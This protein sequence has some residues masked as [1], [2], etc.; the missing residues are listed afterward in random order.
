MRFLLLTTLFL[1]SIHH[2]NSV[3]GK[4]S[5]ALIPSGWLMPPLAVPPA[6]NPTAIALKR[7]AMLAYNSLLPQLSVNI[8]L[9]TLRHALDAVLTPFAHVQIPSHLK[10]VMHGLHML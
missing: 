3:K 7:E 8:D 10:G 6:K 9:P 2:S 1:V 4:Q 5:G